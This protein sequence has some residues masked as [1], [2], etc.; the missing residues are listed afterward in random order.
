[1][2]YYLWSI[3]NQQKGKGKEEGEGK[4]KEEGEGKQILPTQCY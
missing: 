3:Y 1:M 4:S 2:V